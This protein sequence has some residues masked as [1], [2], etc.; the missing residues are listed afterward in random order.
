LRLGRLSIAEQMLQNPA[1]TVPHKQI[2]LQQQ[3]LLKVLLHMQKNSAQN[4]FFDQVLKISEYQSAINIYFKEKQVAASDLSQ[5]IELRL[6]NIDQQLQKLT[7][8]EL[9]PVQKAAK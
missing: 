2:L 1:D 8:S 5:K 9:N 7:P 4:D 3:T 6:Q